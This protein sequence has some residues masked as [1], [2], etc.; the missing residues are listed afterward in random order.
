MLFIPLFETPMDEINFWN[1]WTAG[2]LDFGDTACA[3][4][5]SNEN[6]ASLPPIDGNA[7]P[8]LS[9]NNASAE[10]LSDFNY[11]SS[12]DFS[13]TTLPNM[14]QADL[15]ESDPLHLDFLSDT[16]PT[17]QFPPGDLSSG[18]FQ[19]SLPQLDNFNLPTLLDAEQSDHTIPLH[20]AGA[21]P[22]AEQQIPLEDI[23]TEMDLSILSTLNT[24]LEEQFIA[25]PTAEKNV[26]AKID[27]WYV[28]FIYTGMAD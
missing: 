9:S 22:I 20:I 19:P 10:L 23:S 6:F 7:E 8:R 18:F 27:V 4:P 21:G 26:Q 25:E 17:D 14:F 3:D 15:T 5:G 2:L 12:L 11:L 1:E 16:F 28:L 13:E 24:S